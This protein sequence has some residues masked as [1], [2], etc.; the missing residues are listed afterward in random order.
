MKEFS[1]QAR[2]V[3]VALGPELVEVELKLHLSV[4]SSLVSHHCLT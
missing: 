3:N 2:R 1:G 4:S